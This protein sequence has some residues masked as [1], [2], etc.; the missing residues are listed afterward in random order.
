MAN[1]DQKIQKFVIFDQNQRASLLK[2]PF[3]EKTTSFKISNFDK[4]MPDSFQS[5][6]TF[7]DK[8]MEIVLTTNY[9]KR[10]SLVVKKS[11]S[12]LK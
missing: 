11:V 9:I 8:K 6:N 1:S 10:I 2:T 5:K 12:G 3:L 4:N 7:S